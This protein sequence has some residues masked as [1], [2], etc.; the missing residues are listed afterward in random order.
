MKNTYNKEIEEHLL[1][2]LNKGN[3]KA[4]AKIFNRYYKD[5]VL[6]GG[7]IIFDRNVVEDV[8]Q[9]VFLNV[10]MK[11]FELRIDT[12]LKSYLLK[13][14]YNG[15][16]LAIKN[17]KVT[18]RYQS[19]NS[20]YYNLMLDYDT[21]NYILYSELEEHIDSALKKLPENYRTVFS[22]GKI[23][24]LKYSEISEQLLISER[25]VELWMSKALGLMRIYLKEFLTILLF[26]F[27]NKH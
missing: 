20:D 2:E 3:E 18:Q 21:E 19:E 9:S 5:M 7:N 15:C 22:L 27:V 11:R 17:S 6:F 16:L 26:F 8:V 10:W 12:S 13:S 4:F 25:T 1:I 14:V 24:G 23:K